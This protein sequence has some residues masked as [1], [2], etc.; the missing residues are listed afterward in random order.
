M[1]IGAGSDKSAASV[2]GLMPRALCVLAA[3]AESAAHKTRELFF[4]ILT[5]LVRDRT[6]HLHIVVS[7]SIVGVVFIALAHG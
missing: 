1:N 7:Q 5:L 3:E 4:S 6:E 2:R